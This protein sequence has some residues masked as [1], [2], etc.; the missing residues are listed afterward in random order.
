MVTA[1]TFFMTW[2]LLTEPDVIAQPGT[3]SNGQTESLTR[4]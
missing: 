1:R 4:Q 2:L 3:V